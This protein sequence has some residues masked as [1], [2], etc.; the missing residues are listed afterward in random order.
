VPPFTPEGGHRGEH[1]MRQKEANEK[2]KRRKHK[3]KK[4]GKKGEN[5]HKIE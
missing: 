1:L 2:M 4:E 3:I 5:W